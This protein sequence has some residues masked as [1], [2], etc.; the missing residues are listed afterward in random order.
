MDGS[1]LKDVE[2]WL[3]EFNSPWIEVEVAMNTGNNLCK[4][5]ISRTSRE[6]FAI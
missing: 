4:G 6:G 3:G 1:H 2:F 5:E